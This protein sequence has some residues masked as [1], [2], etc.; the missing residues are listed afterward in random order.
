VHHGEF[1][2][3]NRY[4]TAQWVTEAEYSRYEPNFML[5]AP[6]IPESPTSTDSN[7]ILYQTP[8]PENHGYYFR[9]SSSEPSGFEA[10]YQMGGLGSP[11]GAKPE[12]SGLGSPLGSNFDRESTP[13]DDYW[14]I[15]RASLW[16]SHKECAYES[17]PCHWKG[18]ENKSECCSITPP[19]TFTALDN[20]RPVRKPRRYCSCGVIAAITTIF[21]LIILLLITAFI[22][23][24]EMVL[25]EQRAY[26]PDRM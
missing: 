22:I 1:F 18:E 8:T 11:L 12:K 23:Y 14:H 16:C 7:F 24:I 13:S 2:T 17:K 20:Y 10:K 21:S 9:S 19:P 5:A 26:V 25:K 6:T 15:P 3:H 4:S